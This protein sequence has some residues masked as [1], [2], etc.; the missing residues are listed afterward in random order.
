MGIVVGVLAAVGLTA[1]LIVLF[2][3]R[4]RQKRNAQA[5]NTSVQEVDGVGGGV[6]Y[7]PA[8]VS[9]YQQPPPPAELHSDSP[10]AELD[11][12]TRR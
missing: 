2:A 8:V 12:G 6:W 7:S 11:A 3:R 1:A 4:Q 10:L 5:V 9:K